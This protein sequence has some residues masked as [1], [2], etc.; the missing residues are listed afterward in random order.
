MQ[1]FKCK[2]EETLL[3]ETA[4]H[5]DVSLD[6]DSEDLGE[7]EL[8]GHEPILIPPEAELDDDDDNI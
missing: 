2:T 1:G 3:L 6:M 4:R 7:L 5:D 8:D